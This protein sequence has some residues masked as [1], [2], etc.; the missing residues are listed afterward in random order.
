[1]DLESV[2]TFFSYN[3]W[4]NE[5]LLAAA[6][7]L[8]TEELDR[9]LRGGFGSLQG[10]LRH[11]L[12]GERSWL[13]FWKDD[14]FGPELSASELPDLPS[15]VRE[16]SALDEDR[17]AF[18]RGLTAEKLA[19]P[20]SV[21]EDAYVLGELLQH[22]LNHSTHHRG[23]VVLMLRQLG[24]T[25]PGTGFRS[26]CPRIGEERTR[27]GARTASPVGRRAA[28]TSRARATRW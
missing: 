4:A 5:R 27:R 14:D 10:T 15:I 25:P 19:A 7:E 18:L 21:D 12:W 26:S 16:W 6:G 28:R 3:R 8:S 23:Q 24:K 2:L 13:R 11:L 1:M 22:C 9:D 20:R 17:D